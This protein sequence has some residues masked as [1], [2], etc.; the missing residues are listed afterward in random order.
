MHFI[1]LINP[2][3]TWDSIDLFK[4]NSARHQAVTLMVTIA[5]AVFFIFPALIAFNLLTHT[6]RRIELDQKGVLE[7]Q[8]VKV[9]QVALPPLKPSQSVEAIP[10]RTQAKWKTFFFEQF[11]KRLDPLNLKYGSA[12]ENGD[13]FFDAVAQQLSTPE[14][15]YSKKEIRQALADHLA[16]VNREESTEHALYFTDYKEKLRGDHDT[17][18]ET[19]CAQIGLTLEELKG[20]IPIWGNGA[21][22]QMTANVFQVALQVYSADMMEISIYDSWHTFQDFELEESRP[23]CPEIC[24]LLGEESFIPLS[25]KPERTILLGNLSRAPW[26]HF[27]PL[28]KK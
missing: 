28:F 12:Q 7:K 25:S 21:A 15:S 16:L 3:K 10:S 1:D 14:K 2:S 26:G 5:A 17:D 23:A 19:F 4:K 18:Y 11:Q 6:F 8:V 22:L 24:T 9:Q 13:C 20:S 27:V